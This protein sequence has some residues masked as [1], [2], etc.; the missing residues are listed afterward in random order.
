[1]NF[2]FSAKRC[3]E[4]K[5]HCAPKATKKSVNNGGGW[6]RIEE[7]II[8]GRGGSVWR[9]RCPDAAD[10]KALAALRLKIDGETEYLDREAGEALL[11]AD[12]FA[13]LI[14][15]DAAAE[16][17]LFLV[18]EIDGE[19][20]GFARCVGLTLSRFRHKA[21]FG[22]CIAQSCWGQGIGETMLQTILKWA[23]AVGLKKIAL[24][25]VKENVSAIRLYER[26]GFVCE[27]LLKNDR[28]H[29][30]GQFYDTLIMGRCKEG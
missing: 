28:L 12:S 4:G 9:L 23:D 10:A 8:E 26:C 14:E 11:S 22:I 6:V 30:N 25:V 13:Q 16:R 17:S 24:T 29:R 19:I 18:A 7:A 5:W 20:V 27:G 2:L 3:K 1:M 21:E 15:K